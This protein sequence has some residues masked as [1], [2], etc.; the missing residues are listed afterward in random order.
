L[1]A[2][3][4]TVTGTGR[5]LDLA[6]H[7]LPSITFVAAELSDEKTVAKLLQ[8][9]DSI[10]HCAGLSTLWGTPHDFQVANVEATANLLSA[11]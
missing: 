7:L 2:K 8:E 10:V 3:G 4:N 6:K 1:S 9:H 5:N 11:A